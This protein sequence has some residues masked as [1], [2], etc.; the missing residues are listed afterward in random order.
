[1]RMAGVAHNKTSKDMENHVFLKAKS[2]EEYLSLVARLIIHFRDI[3]NHITL[4][5]HIPSEIYYTSKILF[6][7]SIVE[8]S[9]CAFG[10]ILL[11][12]G[13]PSTTSFV[14]LPMPGHMEKEH[15]LKKLTKKAKKMAESILCIGR[16][17]T[18]GQSTDHLHFV[19]PGESQNYSVRGITMV[20]IHLAV[21]INVTAD[22]LNRRTKEIHEWERHP[23]V[24]T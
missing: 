3:R 11:A 6:T 22:T 17:L 1:M 9:I 4:L 24:L 21:T 18:A 13:A 7:F 2:R 23:E 20:A 15:P 5:T 10:S 8:L 14:L 12:A 19:A 16:R